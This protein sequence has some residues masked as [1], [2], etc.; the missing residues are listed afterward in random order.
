MDGV[1]ETHAGARLGRY[2]LVQRVGEGGMGVVHLALDDAGRAVAVKVLKP[3]VA[4]DP[5]ARR[6]LA[7]E[8]DT[9]RRVRHPR[10]AAVLDA[11]TAGATPFVVT[12]YVPAPPLDAH[13]AA[14]GPLGRRALADL[15]DGLGEALAA[16][17]AAGVVHRDLKP[18]NVLMLDGAPVVIDFGIAHVAD[19]VR[20]TSTGLVMGTPGYLSPEVVAGQRVST[21]T[22]WWGWA[23]TMAFAATGRPPFGRGPVEV[24]LDRVRRGEADLDGVPAGLLD[25]LSRGLEVDP[26]RRPVPG[27]L[28]AAVT[29]LRGERSPVLPVPTPVTA[30]VTQPVRAV[31]A[32]RALERAAAAPQQLPQSLPSS[33]SEPVAYRA[34]GPLPR[35]SGT[36]LAGLV[37]LSAAAAVAPAAAALLGI[38]GSAVA[39]TVDRSH[40][41]VLRRR[42]ERGPRRS[43][44]AWAVAASPARLV[45][46]VLVSVA[47]AVLPL[48]LGASA[49]FLAALVLGQATPAGTAG[50]G[51]ALPLAVGAATAVLTAWWGPGGGSVRRGTR[52]AVRTLAPGRRGAQV[53]V[54]ALVIVAVAAAL[55]VVGGSQPDWS[56]LPG[57][58]F[59]GS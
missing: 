7:R 3:H 58:P 27:E 56:P 24:V 15:G 36:L 42:H 4:G 22:D 35:R 39:R 13:V 17:H 46:A 40:G 49:A 41:A 53:A 21:A 20:L 26:A 25:V 57:P 12:Q 47:A 19:D 32:T 10:V 50:P 37:A 43:D 8:V 9:L 55:V 59:A 14:H 18:G 44:L 16:I 34:P 33:P 48:L 23:A 30:P 2:R 28:R 29:A 52:A 54:A 5:D 6:R 38:A 1:T 51:D 11:D 31:P 45:P